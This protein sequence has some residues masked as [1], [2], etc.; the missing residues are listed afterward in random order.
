MIYVFLVLF[1]LC[2]GSFINAL[3]WRIHEQAKPKAKRVA[4][5]AELSIATG[6]SMC[7]HCKHTL[8]PIDLVPFFSWLLL[9]GKCRYCSHVIDDTPI[10]EV[11]LPI[12]FVLSYVFWPLGLTAGGMVLFGL[13]LILLVI[14]TALMLYDFRWMLLPDRMVFPLIALSLIFASVQGFYFGGGA[15]DLLGLIASVLIAGGLFYVLFQ[16]SDGKWIGGGDVKL[17][18]GLGLI[19]MTPA[20]ATLM[21]FTASVFGLVATLPF[22]LAGK[23][24][25]KSH[26]P[27]GPFLILGTIFAFLFGADV[28]H[29]YTQQFLFL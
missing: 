16:I 22:M 6:R 4:S 27:F 3:V 2:L 8:A 23:A 9:R 10:T 1:G 7:S 26:I 18:Y 12:L 14:L 13:W 24:K 21:L 28:I 19:L 11:V 29:W 20:R 15:G 25:A 5:D 17:G